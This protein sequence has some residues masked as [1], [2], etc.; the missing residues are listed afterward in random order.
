MLLREPLHTFRE[1]CWYVKLNYSCHGSVLPITYRLLVPTR[2][3]LADRRLGCSELS[4][5]CQTNVAN[6]RYRS[7]H[8]SAALA[9]SP[10]DFRSLGFVTQCDETGH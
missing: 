2:I 8:S 4:F 7:T 1:I 5:D 3:G 9:I 6:I 10:A